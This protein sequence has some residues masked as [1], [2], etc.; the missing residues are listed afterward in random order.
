VHKKPGFILFLLFSILSVC[1]V[2]VSLYFMQVVTYRQL[3][4]VLVAKQKTHRLALSG[5]ALAHSVITPQEPND[6]TPKEEKAA[7]AKA[8]TN[9]DQTLLK[10]LAPFF[11]KQESYKLTQK[12]D[13]VDA[14]LSIA[15]QSEQGK[16][17]LNSLY[18]FEKKKF[19]NEGQP[20]DRKKLCTWLFE[21]IASITKKPS[22]FPAFEKHLA[23]RGLDFNDVTELLSIK[24]FET[25][26]QSNVFL[27]FEASEKENVFLTDIFTVS[28]EQDTINPWLLSQSWC[29]IL[30][31]KPKQNMSQEEINKLFS[32][33]AKTAKWETD[34]NNSL[35]DLYQKEYKDLAQEVK[36]ILTTQ[37]EANI[38]SLLL[39][40]NINETSSTIF[41][42]V[43]SKAK[44]SLISIEV[45]KAYQI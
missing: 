2:I 11:N 30:G 35:K 19:L 7:V 40:A 27:N 34:W 44:N 29:K 41:T 32:K 15:V 26:F 16:L 9:T 31:L 22:L 43:R 28:T 18:D 20:N 38:F 45:M 5:V 36:T 17:N 10:Q 21:K 4:T 6:Q 33:C 12:A 37:F 23:S 3:M 24:E 13:G 1:S 42:I 39:K 8:E 25:A 14:T